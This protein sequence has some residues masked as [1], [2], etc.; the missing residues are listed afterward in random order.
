[1]PLL[2]QVGTYDKLHTFLAKTLLA[3]MYFELKEID[4]LNSLLQSFKIFIKR[5]K[6]LGYHREG[7]LNF[8]KF[9][10]KLIN[11]KPEDNIEDLFKEISETKVLTEKVWLLEQVEKLG[12]ENGR[13]LI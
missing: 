11:L 13:S 5:K 12:S 4:S 7:S 10:S 3:K 1:M 2:L 9:I 8:I 6:E